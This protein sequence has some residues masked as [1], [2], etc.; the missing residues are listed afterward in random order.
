MIAVKPEILKWARETA[1]LDLDEAARKI[2]ADSGTSTALEKMQALENGE[3]ELTQNQLFKLAKAYHQPLIVFY[4]PHPPLPEEPL[5]DFRSVP[6][7]GFDRK[8]DAR[9]GLLIRDMKTSQGIIRSLLEDE[10]A[11]VRDFVGSARIDQGVAH[12][13]AEIKAALDFDLNTFRSQT[14]NRDAFRYLRERIESVG[15]FALLQCDL[16]S[17]HTTIPVDIF[18][19]FALAD[20]IAPYI[21]INRQDAVA[22]WS[23]TA[24]HEAAHLW[25]GKSS[26]STVYSQSTI[27]RFCNQVAAS[28]LLPAQD[29]Q[30]IH[31]PPAAELDEIA[32]RINAVADEWKISRTMV[33]Y[34]LR[35]SGAIGRARWDELRHLFHAEWEESKSRDKA[36]SRSR[37]G[38]PSY[39]AVR[40]SHLG[41]AL[42]G[43]SRY[44]L[45]TGDLMPTKAGIVLGVSASTVFPLLHPEY[46]EGRA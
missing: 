5:E 14:S 23:F 2:Y 20:P 4:L 7:G 12:L 46:F 34:N 44:F 24:L 36:D 41:A 15:I 43:T 6:A 8:D 37:K 28:I 3:R 27:E 19:G 45:D 40:R 21:V 31:L 38:G 35:L 26:V 1:G 18:R 16:G 39:Y 32:A 33:A 29:L 17:H 42:V 11:P 13:A 30:Q 10:D 22:A 9:L 25:L